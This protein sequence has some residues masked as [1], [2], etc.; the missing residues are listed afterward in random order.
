MWIETPPKTPAATLFEPDTDLDSVCTPLRCDD[1]WNCQVSEVYAC[2]PVERS[3]ACS[4]V[5]SW[6]SSGAPSWVKSEKYDLQAKVER[7]HTDQLRELSIDQYQLMLQSLLAERFR[8]KF[9]W[10]TK[11]LPV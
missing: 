4:A 9:H 1:C 11:N 10:E 2:C 8:L 7:D 3:P 6:S 5:P